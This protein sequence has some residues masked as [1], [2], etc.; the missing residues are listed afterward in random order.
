MGIL[1]EFDDECER[2]A[3]LLAFAE[4]ILQNVFFP[5]NY[6][7]LGTADGNIRH[8]YGTVFKDY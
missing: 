6:F 4:G 1:S 7:H 2:Y 5:G 8:S 3:V